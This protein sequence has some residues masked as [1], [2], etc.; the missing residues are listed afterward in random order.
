MTDQVNDQIIQYL[1]RLRAEIRADHAR[2]MSA[3]NELE[4]VMRTNAREFHALVDRVQEDLA[5]N[6]AQAV[7]KLETLAV[8]MGIL[9]PNQVKQ[10]QT[11]RQVEHQHHIAE[12]TQALE[13]ERGREFETEPIPGFLANGGRA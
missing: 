2:A 3:G 6:H 10:K 9:A 4:Q 7:E 13:Q 8:S 11:H 12:F 5:V 1:D